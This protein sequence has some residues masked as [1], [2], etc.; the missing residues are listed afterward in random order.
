MQP[1]PR[2]ECPKTWGLALFAASLFAPL[3]AI[4]APAG[5][6]PLGL[7]WAIPFAG[8]LV[9]I[10]LGPT[11]AR[12]AWHRIAGAVMGGWSVALLIAEAAAWGPA[13]AGRTLGHALLNE[14][15]P[16]I[17]LLVALYVSGGGIVVRGGPWG[18]PSGNTLLLGIGT[19]LGSV[20]GTTAAAM[21]FV[22]PLLR[23][24]AHRRRQ[25][26]LIVFFI[27]LVANVGGALSP[28]GD[29]PLY[30]GFLHG[31]PFFWP[32]RRLF[33]PM[34]L[35]VGP[36]LGGFYVLDRYLSG[37]EAA[38]P[39]VEALRVEGIVNVVLVGVVAAS[40]AALGGLDLGVLVLAGDNVPVNRL[41]SAVICLA[42]AALS[43]ALTRPELRR[44]NRFT[45]EPIGEVAEVFFA[46]FITIG[47][48]LAM[49]RAGEA[50]PFAAI[51]RMVVNGNGT[52]I[53]LGYFL[54]T[55][56]LSSFLDNAPTYLVFFGLAGGDASAL[57]GALSHV[58]IAI[59]TGAVFFGGLTYIGNAPNLMVR[60]IAEH[61]GVRVPGFL[62]YSGLAALV[63]AGPLLLVAVLG[64]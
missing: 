24:N 51:V 22:H 57:A 3:P 18:R 29:P 5:G 36:L 19:L 11:L 1:T 54:L 53:P 30:M 63:L 46:I 2:R 12:G 45:W 43:L 48:V 8:V 61:R 14:Y 26:H 41:A 25:G 13:A 42:V 50:G 49:L 38:A 32:L 28:I 35:A 20:I 15:L 58:L 33:F 62:E 44:T 23:A 37:R 64:L 21:V 6:A 55:G 34:L 52:P 7:V 59:S 16:F 39:G 47:P 60:A 10:A 40:V 4:A 56:L 9:S 27:V 31:V 17:S